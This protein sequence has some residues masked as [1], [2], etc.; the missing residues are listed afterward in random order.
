MPILLKKVEA[1]IIALFS[2]SSSNLTAPIY[3]VKNIVSVAGR[4]DYIKL[5]NFEAFTQDFSK[6]SEA[7]FI[8]SPTTYGLGTCSTYVDLTISY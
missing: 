1:R 8:T 3:F 2:N 6:V 4:E 7:N 5:T